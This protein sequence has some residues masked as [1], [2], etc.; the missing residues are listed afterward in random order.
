MSSEKR[1]VDHRYRCALLGH[2]DSGGMDCAGLGTEIDYDVRMEEGYFIQTPI[3]P[4]DCPLA[5]SSGPGCDIVVR[6]TPGKVA[7]RLVRQSGR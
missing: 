1:P 3:T 6:S 4:P 2:T 7:R 5:Q